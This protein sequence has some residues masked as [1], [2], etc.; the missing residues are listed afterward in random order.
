MNKLFHVLKVEKK[1]VCLV[2]FSILRELLTRE[3]YLSQH[4]TQSAVDWILHSH[5][6]IH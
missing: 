4:N 6:E 1:G 5:A 2:W 3:N